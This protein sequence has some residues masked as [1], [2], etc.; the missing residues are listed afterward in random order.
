MNPEDVLGA[1][2]TARRL[3]DWQTQRPTSKRQVLRAMI[4]ATRRLLGSILFLF[5]V[6]GVLFAAFWLVV[7]HPGPVVIAV[8]ITALLSIWASL[9]QDALKD[10][11]GRRS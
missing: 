11:R 4:V 6:V 1:D 10:E 5:V 3:K 9:F 7:Q 8:L 2:L